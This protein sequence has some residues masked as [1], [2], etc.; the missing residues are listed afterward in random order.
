MYNFSTWQN[1]WIIEFFQIKKSHFHQNPW[2]QD[3]ISTSPQWAQ[4]LTPS[5]LP[6]LAAASPVV[7]NL[8]VAINY[9]EAS[10][11]LVHVFKLPQIKCIGKTPLERIRSWILVSPPM[12][13][14]LESQL[15]LLLFPTCEASSLGRW[16]WCY[17]HILNCPV[18]SP[19]TARESLAN[20]PL[21]LMQ[22]MECL[23]AAENYQL[24]ATGVILRV[25][26]FYVTDSDF[27]SAE[28]VC[29][30]VYLDAICCY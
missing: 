5:P 1:V 23:L 16:C 26:Q 30:S 29:V 27:F 10:M 12:G 15:G 3:F 2:G 13:L 19:A 17:L 28:S 6:A 21:A 4:T 24:N 20:M 14:E 18:L 11:A 9:G 25:V 7:L 8:S 22:P